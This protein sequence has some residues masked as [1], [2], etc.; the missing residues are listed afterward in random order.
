M[1]WVS[2]CRKQNKSLVENRCP[3]SNG[4]I[5]HQLLKGLFGTHENSY[6]VFC[7]FSPSLAY[8]ASETEVFN[9]PVRLSFLLP[10]CDHL[11]L[12]VCDDL[13]LRAAILAMGYQHCS[14]TQPRAKI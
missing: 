3:N 10:D 6:S 2:I 13:Y 11:S 1:L 4:R 7:S 5:S 9:C 8:C 12:T 14:I